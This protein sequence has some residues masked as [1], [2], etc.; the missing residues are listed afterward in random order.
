MAL[1]FILKQ[2]SDNPQA[3]NL[4]QLSN[5]THEKIID[6]NATLSKYDYRNDKEIPLDFIE[7]KDGKYKLIIELL[8]EIKNLTQIEGQTNQTYIYSIYVNIETKEGVKQIELRVNPQTYN[9]F[10][11]DSGFYK[12]NLKVKKIL[13]NIMVYNPTL[14]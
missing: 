7:K 11:P 10:L 2:F 1:F 12:A 13:K 4:N 8:R 5:L 3:N 6:F 9:L 14:Q